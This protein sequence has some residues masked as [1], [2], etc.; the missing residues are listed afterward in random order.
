MEVI[1]EKTFQNPI[2]INGADPWMYK[3]TDG[4]YYFMVTKGD[5]LELMRSRSMSQIA[6]GASKVVWLP[7]AAGMN[8]RNLWAPEIH[9]IQGK[10]YIYFTA[11]DGGGDDTRRVYVL[12]N[13]S[14]DPF[15]GDWVE[16]GAVN[17]TYA[18]LD[19]SVLAHH[20]KLFFMYAGYGN[21][22]EYGSAIY[23]AE[24]VNPWTIKGDNVLLSKPE[25]EWEK[26]GGMAINE[27]PC[28]LNRNGRVFLIYSASTCWSDDYA[29]GMLSAP[30]SSDLL[31]PASWTKSE[32]AVFV[33]SLQNGVFGPGHNSFTVS[34]DGT[35]D[36]IV[37]HAIPT[38]GGGSEQRS[39]RM[40][41]FSWHA[42]GTPNFG[43]PLPQDTTIPVP[44]GEQ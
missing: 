34:P 19:G 20:G 5:R 35:E 11:N 39:T 7:P 31:D 41:K 6:Q 1:V 4:Q 16:K 40:Q 37:Y 14:N 26:Q 36:W 27:G 29:L 2:L 32:T 33:K 17:T 28:F 44:A 13:E 12:E 38:S 42:D 3:H 25:F 22:P 43:T 30:E 21:F 8:S 10:W 15:V 9:H 18:G 24:M 23:A